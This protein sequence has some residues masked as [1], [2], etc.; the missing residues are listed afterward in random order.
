MGEHEEG[1]RE[2]YT[3]VARR[4]KGPNAMHVA[5]FRASIDASLSPL[6]HFRFVPFLTGDGSSATFKLRGP[7][8]TPFF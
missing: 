4:V 7:A 5:P 2:L 6:S 3:P 8:A 1:T